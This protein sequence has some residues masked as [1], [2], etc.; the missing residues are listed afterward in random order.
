MHSVRQCWLRWYGWGVCWRQWGSVSVV[1]LGVVGGLLS[2][3]GGVAASLAFGEVV[4]AT[5]TFRPLRFLFLLVLS[6]LSLMVADVGPLPDG[7]GV[8]LLC[9]FVLLFVGLLSSLV[10][11]PDRRC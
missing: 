5:V 8:S 6:G 2:R 4:E 11:L 7:L 9:L 10:S 1:F 3:L